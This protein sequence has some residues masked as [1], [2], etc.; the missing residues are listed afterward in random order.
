MHRTL[1]L[2][3]LSSTPLASTLLST[4]ACRT[5]AP[6]RAAPPNE[7]TLARIFF[8]RARPGMV[9]EYDRYIRDVAE[10]IDREGRRRGAFVS[11]TTTKAP[12]T[13]LSWTHMRVFTLRDSVQ[14]AAFGPLLDSAAAALEPDSAKRRARGEHTATLRDRVGDV[15]IDLDRGK[16]PYVPLPGYGGAA[17]REGWTRGADGVRL[18]YRLVGAGGDTLVFVHGGPGTGMR[19]GYD[20][21]RLVPLGRA[22]LM[23]DQRGAGMSEPVS[24]PARLRLTD[25]VADLD[26]VLRR[27]RLT[28]AKLLALSWGSAIAA[29]WAAEHPDAADR[30][31]FV[32]PISPT[33]PLLVARFAHLDTVAGRPDAGGLARILADAAA[34]AS[35]SALAAACHGAALTSLYR[36]G[37]PHAV[38]PRGDVCDYPAAVLRNRLVSRLAGIRSLGEEYDLRPSL[39]GVRAPAVVVEGELTNVPL[40]ATREF[41]AAL[42]N[43]RLV[44]VPDAGHQHWLDRPDVVFPM[45]DAFFR[46]R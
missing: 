41:A 10:P 30:I 25:H 40:D 33:W 26:A 43:G 35:D 12:D 27:S 15:T 7:P 46:T 2:A 3:A 8:W 22:L 39:R 29:R 34:P 13:T 5:R 21:E 36:H 11:V 45:L 17:V 9:D 44:L 4:L 18:F 38:T 24:D 1:R 6:A 37:G 14:L 28:R 23:Y 20:F 19:E 16:L 31:A 32:S 42:P